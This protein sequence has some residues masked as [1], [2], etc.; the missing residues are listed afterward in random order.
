M[1]FIVVRAALAVLFVLPVE[2]SAEVS[3][4]GAQHH[5]VRYAGL[6]L[7]SRD[8]VAMLDARILRAVRTV[9]GDGY[10]Q[11]LTE[12]MAVRKCQAQATQTA[13]HQVDLA[14]AKAN[15]RHAGKAA[16]VAI[17]TVDRKGF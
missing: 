1:I 9:C 5:E 3:N 2:V 7:R 14:V 12:R 4:V 11:T 17:V 16:Q 6:D 13:R 8:S 10:H 15:E